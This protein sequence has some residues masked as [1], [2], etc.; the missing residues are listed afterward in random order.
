MTATN[1]TL[2]YVA[3]PMDPY[4][5]TIREIATWNRRVRDNAE[6]RKVWSAADIKRAKTNGQ[7]GIIFGF[8]NSAMV[9]EDPSRVETFGN[10]GVR[11]IQLTYNVR[12]QVGDGSMVAENRGLTETGRA[13]VEQL[14]ANRI[15]VDL[16]HSGEQTCLDAVQATAA[17]IVRS[18][19]SETASFRQSVSADPP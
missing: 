13:V 5:F 6:L 9:E 17:P 7:V 8:Q 12:N 3:G 4:E 10:L 16:S 18:H 14:N 2:G 15:L 11:V 19:D 1:V